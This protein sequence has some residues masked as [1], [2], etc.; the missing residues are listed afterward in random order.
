MLL[1]SDRARRTNDDGTDSPAAGDDDSEV[2]VVPDTTGGDGDSSGQGRLD[3]SVGPEDEPPVVTVEDARYH[4][5]T[6]DATHH[7]PVPEMFHSD[8]YGSR[9]SEM[10]DHVID[11]E[12]VPSTRMS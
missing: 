6:W 5:T 9:L 8:E 1:E 7:S 3:G 4:P 2:G 11:S 10:I 12:E